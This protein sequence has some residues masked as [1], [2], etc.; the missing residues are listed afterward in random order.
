MKSHGEEPGRL[1]SIELQELDMTTVTEQISSSH[2]DCQERTKRPVQ[3]D[4][5]ACDKKPCIKEELGCKRNMIKVVDRQKTVKDEAGEIGRG[6]I[7][8]GL[9]S[10]FP[11]RVMGSLWKLLS[12]TKTHFVCREWVVLLE[13]NLRARRDTK[14]CWR[15]THRQ[16]SAGECPPIAP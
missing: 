3:V 16:N 6:Q 2:S 5:T 13:H 7:I 8:Q 15:G 1:Q 10:D 12:R 9:E 11:F 4:R 14:R